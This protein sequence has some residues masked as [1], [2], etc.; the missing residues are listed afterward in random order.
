MQGEAIDYQLLYPA[1]YG[2]AGLDDERVLAKD[3]VYLTFDCAP[4]S[5]TMRIL[6]IL[7]EYGVKATFFLM[8]TDDQEA[9]EVMSQ[10]TSRGHAIGLYSYS[11]SYPE[12]YDSVASYLADFEKIYN[13]VYENTGV[14]AEIFRFPGGSVNSYNSKIYRELVGEMIRRN[15][16]FFDWNHSG[17]DN[18]S[19]ADEI[20]SNVFAT[21][22]GAERAI[23][24]LNDMVRSEAVADALPDIIGGLRDQ[25]YSF[26]PL[27]ANVMP[28]IFSYKSTP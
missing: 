18:G 9:P 6:D 3:T 15:I 7:D 24:S 22:L 11:G 20:K 1:L 8:G 17:G 10:I 4:R 2:T 26:Q 23:I 19:T 16:I 25:G 13:W 27:A 14:R 28:V 5:N 21:A 12:I